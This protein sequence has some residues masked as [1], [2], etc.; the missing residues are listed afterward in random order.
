MLSQ[1]N[2]CLSY[3]QKMTGLLFSLIL[4]CSPLLLSAQDDNLEEIIEHKPVRPM[5]ESVWLIDNQSVSTNR[6]GTFEMDILHRFGV[7]NKGYEDL[8]GLFAPSNIRLG[9]SYAITD[10]LM[11][12]FGVTKSNFIWD[13]NLKY[14]I[15]R[16]T[17]DNYMPLSLTFFGNTAIDSRPESNFVNN[18]DRFS[19][20][21]Q[22][23]LA[24][25]INSEF[26]IQVSPTFSHFNAVPGVESA[27]GEVTAVINN[28][29]LAVSLG[30]RYM[31]GS[32][33]SLIANYDQPI[34]KHN[35]NNPHPNLSFGLE[36]S[37][38][39]HAFQ[40]FVGNYYNITP[41]RNNLFN[42]NDYRDGEILIGFNIT[43]L[44]SL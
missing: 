33:M 16:Q 35:N 40:L 39:S 43:R 11:T 30:G 15:L 4:L 36:V 21:S 31:I 26:S 41:Q 9:F 12:G 22:L 19:Y 10:K 44:W 7:V 29:H 14:A 6:Q 28:D 38:S 8:Y 20:F 1:N 3:V 42:V 5:F 13:L 2:T 32:N 37:T 23:I 27:D 25:K 18:S 17:R 24:R 34:T